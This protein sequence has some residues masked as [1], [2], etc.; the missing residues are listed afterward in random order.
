MSS[1]NIAPIQFYDKENNGARKIPNLGIKFQ[2]FSFSM[3]TADYFFKITEQLSHAMTKCVFRSLRPSKTQTDLL[4][5][6][7]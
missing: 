7:S 2:Y 1:V 6:R 4:S 5:Y 3:G